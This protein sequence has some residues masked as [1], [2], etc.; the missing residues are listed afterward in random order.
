MRPSGL[1]LIAL[2]PLTMK[3]GKK[4]MIIL[5]LL[6][7]VLFGMLKTAYTMANGMRSNK[8]AA[9]VLSTGQEEKSM[10]DIG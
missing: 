10:R 7:E 4:I 6:I 8:N 5:I 9:E 1:P 2:Y 3:N